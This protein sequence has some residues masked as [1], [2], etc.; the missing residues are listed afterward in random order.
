MPA[1]FNADLNPKNTGMSLSDMMKMGLYSAE[2]DVLNRQ[3]QVAREK[4]K[5]MPLTQA[6]MSKTENYQTDGRI[7]P[8]KVMPSLMAVAPITGPAII[9]KLQTLAQ[10]Q[11][12]I[13]ESRMK[14][15][16]DERTVFAQV[17]GAL[18]QSKIDDPTTYI[19]AYKNIA[20]QYPYNPNIAKLAE[21]K[22]SNVTLANK[23]QHLWEQALRSSNQMMTLPE[24]NV[25]FTP[26]A[27]MATIG[28]AER[29]ITTTP[30]IEGRP[31]TITPGGFGG[32]PV[33]GGT[34][35]TST[36]P[37]GSTGGKMPELIKYGSLKARDPELLNLDTAQQEARKIGTPMVA[38]APL[39]IKAAKDIQQPI[40]KVEEYIN[41]A[42][43]SKLYQTLQAGGKY[44]WGNADLDALVKNIAQ[45]QARNAEV[46]GL[47]KTDHMQDLNA[48][49][50]GS[51]KIDAK[52]LAGVMQQVKADAVAAEKYNTGLLKFVEK[53][54]DVNGQILAKKF[55]SAWAENYDPRIFQRQNIENSQLS[56][57]EQDKRIREIDAGMTKEEFKDLENKAKI[58]HRLEKGLYQ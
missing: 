33:G 43:G 16:K 52:A 45:V 9:E 47:A 40:R 48:K 20:E 55:Q 6:I 4:E 29:V 51:E 27:S 34:T 25:A 12:A 38:D 18:G 5:E 58:L 32:Q 28:G 31:P 42:S 21:A 23:G 24:Q 36:M 37:T 26:K 7:D 17:E 10:N 3:A 39:N 11:T 1:Q 22:I 8:D 50:S 53:H 14:L 2:A 13:T 54:G 44:A 35:T 30:S 49:L 41:S 56:E 57:R 46:M 15:T 19:N